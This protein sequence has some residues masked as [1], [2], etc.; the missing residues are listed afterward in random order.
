[1]SEPSAPSVCKQAPGLFVPVIDR[2]RCEGKGACVDVC[3][4]QVFV[5]GVLAPAER[6]GLSWRGRLKGWAHRWR[7]A[8][9]AQPQACEACGLCVEACPEQAITLARAAPADRTG[10]HPA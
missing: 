2:N 1:V 5:L 3:P 10:G 6:V 7:Q 8:R 4:K 9:L